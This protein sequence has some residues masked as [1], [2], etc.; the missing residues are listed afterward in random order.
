M[1][2]I[3]L[4]FGLSLPPEALSQDQ[5]RRLSMPDIDHRF[6]Q[7]TMVDQFGVNFAI[8]QLLLD[9]YI[10]KQTYILGPGDMFSIDI[11]GEIN[12]SVRGLLVNGEGNIFIPGIGQVEVKELTLAEARGIIKEKIGERFQQTEVTVSLDRPRPIHVRVHGNVESPGIYVVPYQTRVDQAI[13][14]AI[15]GEAAFRDT[16]TEEQETTIRSRPTYFGHTNF[17]YSLSEIQDMS[18]SFRNIRI[19]SEDGQN[20]SADLISFFRRGDK[21]ANP[22]VEDGD[23]IHIQRRLSEGP[24]VSISGGVNTHL[25]LEYRKGDDLASVIEIAGGYSSDAD[26]TQIHLY[27]RENN[28]IIHYTFE[29]GQDDFS[30][31]AIEP[32]DK[33]VVPIDREL[34]QSHTAHINGEV[35][36]P[37]RYPI[38]EGETTLYDLLDMSGGETSRALSHGAYLIRSES[39]GDR[40][41]KE[42]RPGM[43]E[44]M[45][46]SDQMQQGFEYLELETALSRNQVHVDLA[47]EEQLKNTRLYEGDQL[48]I[49]KDENTVFMMGQVNE[50]G[51]FTHNDN[52]VDR[53]IERAGGF[54]MAAEESRVFVIKAGSRSWHHPEETE[55]ESG[56]IIFVDRVPYD[57]L[58]ARRNYRQG[59]I[60]LILTGISTVATVITTYIAVFR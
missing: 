26:T 11:K 59:N 28:E 46:T 32:N 4:V 10:D 43:Q 8:D 20:R 49:P 16:D 41:L 7:P 12:Q 53:Y 47:N 42:S 3:L 48:Y 36:M 30:E 39:A 44:L 17:Q 15:T 18:H 14:P 50:P 13:Y 31:V 2:A 57:D 1:L 33:V 60:Q 45:R 52:S 27:R 21:E 23:V 6:L 56:D 40:T 22:Y 5:E 55:I 35:G 24:M 19:E 58:H 37:G 51:H 34:H 25:D 38:V 9:Q 54:A 29:S